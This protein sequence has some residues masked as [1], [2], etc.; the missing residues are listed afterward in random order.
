MIFTVKSLVVYL[1]YC[2][3]FTDCYSRQ[4]T[5]KNLPVLTFNNGFATT[6]Y[7]NRAVVVD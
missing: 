1:L 6:F 5:L 7:P 3:L 4:A 2:M